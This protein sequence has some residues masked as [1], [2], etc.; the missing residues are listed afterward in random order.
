MS[1]GRLLWVL[2]FC[3]RN[4]LRLVISVLEV[5]MRKK[6]KYYWWVLHFS[7]P[8]HGLENT[9]VFYH[10]LKQCNSFFLKD[11]VWIHDGWSFPADLQKEFNCRCPSCIS[12][13]F[14]CCCVVLFC[15]VL[16]GEGGGLIGWLILFWFLASGLFAFF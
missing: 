6:I 9:C 2:Y 3:Y 13:G 12:G 1:V 14:C 8:A 7:F 11:K 5:L 4:N 16:G 10:L 15:F